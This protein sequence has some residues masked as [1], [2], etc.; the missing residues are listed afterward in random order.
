MPQTI[1]HLQV[2][3]VS[4]FLAFGMICTLIGIVIGYFIRNF[5]HKKMARK[6][7]KAKRRR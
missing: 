5:V 7:K 4:V 3:F 2:N 1:S 6:K